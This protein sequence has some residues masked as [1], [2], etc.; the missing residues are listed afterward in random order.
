MY[1]CSLFQ[2]PS[3]ALL[4]CAAETDKTLLDQ[5]DR[6]RDRASSNVGTDRDSARDLDGFS[7]SAASKYAQPLRQPAFAS[8]LTH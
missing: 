7:P 2:P 6:T 3:E 5:I 4:A 1:T 8:A